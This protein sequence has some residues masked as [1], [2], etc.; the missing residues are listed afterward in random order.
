MRAAVENF[1]GRRRPARRA[2]PRGEARPRRNQKGS[3]AFRASEYYP[4][5]LRFPKRPASPVITTPDIY[6]RL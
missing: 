4:G 6:E 5:N 1:A 2:T 3:D